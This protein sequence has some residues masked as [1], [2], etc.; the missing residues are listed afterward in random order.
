MAQADTAVRLSHLAGP[1]EE[2][3]NALE[4]CVGGGVWCKG[5]DEPL[6]CRVTISKRSEGGRQA[7]RQE[8]E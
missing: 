2:L 8:N 7:G 6:L 3:P 4:D 1:G 5:D